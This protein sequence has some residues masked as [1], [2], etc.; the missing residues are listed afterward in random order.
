MGTRMRLPEY[1]L[2]FTGAKRAL[3]TRAS[4][5][6]YA[7]RVTILPS[8][9]ERLSPLEIFSDLPY[10]KRWIKKLHSCY[11]FTP[12]GSGRVSGMRRNRAHVANS[13]VQA[14]LTNEASLDV[15]FSLCTATDLLLLQM[16]ECDS[17]IK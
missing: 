14:P 4:G 15:H 13:Y 3:D 11:S 17:E 1:Y 7:Q 8:G 12:E 5:S 16:V 2:D 6:M 9:I 10:G